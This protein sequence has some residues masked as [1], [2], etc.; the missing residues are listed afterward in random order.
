MNGYALFASDGLL[1][2]TS[3]VNESSRIFGRSV[4]SKM[5]SPSTSSSTHC[6]VYSVST[7]LLEHVYV[8]NVFVELYSTGKSIFNS[9]LFLIAVLHVNLNVYIEDYPTF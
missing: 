9:V 4:T 6:C 7:S 8:W 3:T 2:V 5:R 1:T